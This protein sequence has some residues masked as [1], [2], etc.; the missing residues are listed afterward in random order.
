[1]GLEEYINRPIPQQALNDPR[2]YTDLMTTLRQE[3]ADNSNWLAILSHVIDIV[4]QVVSRFSGVSPL[5]VTRALFSGDYTEL[6][7]ELA[8]RHGSTAAAVTV[9]DPETGAPCPLTAAA[10]RLAAGLGNLG[11]ADA[12]K[13]LA[14]VL[15]KL[16]K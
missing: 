12:R 8:A 14:D 2:V 13:A 1:M 6:E 10:T 9:T 16:A 3:F 11:L 7:S 5:V 15:S 4:D